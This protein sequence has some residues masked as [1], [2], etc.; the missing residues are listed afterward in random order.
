M[1]IKSKKFMAGMVATA[2]LASAAIPGMVNAEEL[3]VKENDTTIETTSIDVPGT[4]SEIEA[5]SKDTSGVDIDSNVLKG[6]NSNK[7]SERRAALEKKFNIKLTDKMVWEDKKGQTTRHPNGTVSEYTSHDT[8]KSSGFY[9]VNA[10]RQELI[11]Y[12]IQEGDWQPYRAFAAQET[13]GHF[14]IVDGKYEYNK[15]YY[16]QLMS[17]QL[18]SYLEKMVELNMKYGYT[19]EEKAAIEEEK[20]AHKTEHK[21]I[22]AE[23]VEKFNNAPGIVPYVVHL[24]H[25]EDVAKEYGVEMV[26]KGY[27]D[28]KYN[29]PELLTG[30]AVLEGKELPVE[31]VKEETKVTETAK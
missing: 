17:S 8:M 10:N 19:P 5:T 4:G 11:Q 12:G 6:L 31:E 24:N 3:E 13:P 20:V 22:M 15:I 23:Y 28:S 29:H 1:L 26:A 30:K 27:F 2:I 25:R 9:A 7:D 14:E 16:G 21:R 18:T